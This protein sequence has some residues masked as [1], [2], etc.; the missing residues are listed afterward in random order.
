MTKEI[1]KVHV[2]DLDREAYLFMK[3]PQGADNQLKNKETYVGDRLR[4]AFNPG[5]NIVLA[6][7]RLTVSNPLL[8]T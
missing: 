1:L 3:Y 8:T 6:T 5:G 7:T 2:E 4:L